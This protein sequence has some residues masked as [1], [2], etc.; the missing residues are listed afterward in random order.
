MRN[1]RYSFP[2]SAR[3]CRC[4]KPL[5]KSFCGLAKKVI[6]IIHA[7]ERRNGFTRLEENVT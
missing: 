5:E 4:H 3:T 1:A 6:F 2:S 7:H